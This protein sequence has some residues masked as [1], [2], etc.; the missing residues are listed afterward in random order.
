[1]PGSTG[2]L[3]SPSYSKA[4]GNTLPAIC[5]ALAEWGLIQDV[6]YYVGRKAPAAAGF[7][8]PKRPPLR[9]A[10]ANCFH[11][12]NGTVLVIL[13][14]AQGM[15]ANS[16]SLDWLIGP[17]AKFLNYDKIK[18]EINPA[19]R[20]NR[21]DF[22]YSPLHHSVLYSSDMPTSK[23]GRWLLEKREAMRPEHIDLIRELY[24]D[25][26]RLKRLP[27][28]N[29]YVKRQI[30]EVLRDISIARKYQKPV[31]ETKRKKREYAVF[32]GEYDVFDNLEVLG[33]DFIHEMYRDSPTLIWLTAFLNKRLLKVANGFY[34]ALDDD[35]HFYIPDDPGGLSLEGFKSTNK[36]SE[37]CLTDY[38]LD[39]YAPLHVAFDSNAAISSIAISQ[40]DRDANKLRTVRS[41]FVKTPLKL[42][43]LV[44]KTCKYYALKPIKEVVVYYDQTFTWTTGT[45]D[46]SYAD[47]I[48]KYFEMNDF[49][50]T[51]V[52]I[53][54]QPPHE[55]RH[56]QIDLA[57]KGDASLLYPLFN[58]FN[59]EYL[60]LA[61]EQAA[62]R[63]GKDGFEKDKTP[64][65]LADSED[66]PD[67]YKTHITDAW[68]TLFVGTNFF[69]TEPYQLGGGVIFL[70][71]N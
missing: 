28:Q 70:G 45:T 39:M 4:W 7:K 64:E 50:V 3:I 36:Q 17:E 31:K 41:D 13:S 51:M 42:Q 61:M 35:L 25:W 44:Q 71:K 38:D 26:L 63:T 2:G 29:D 9:D 8:Q 37:S 48:K 34:S 11:F 32:Y 15:S 19:N 12:W 69:Y 59:N 14:F 60:K 68:D 23:M 62:V 58:L 21:K 49:D 52:Y 66:N 24:R 56:K 43:D 54:Q 47:T 10:W 57:M 6:H 18:S 30:K 1:M 46:E 22:G 16:M 53:G 20:G 33:E 55:W 65:K 67:E 27:D 5:K 40:V